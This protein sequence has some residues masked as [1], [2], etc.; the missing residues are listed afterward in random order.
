MRRTKKILNNKSAATNGNK[1]ERKTERHVF[2]TVAIMQIGFT[3][4]MGMIDIV[5][6]RSG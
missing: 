1:K 4:A 2:I 3:V 5:F 6:F